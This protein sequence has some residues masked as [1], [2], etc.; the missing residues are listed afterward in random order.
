MPLASGRHPFKKGCMS[1]NCIIAFVLLAV[2]F[3]FGLQASVIIS[4]TEFATTDWNETAVW[5]PS[6]A[7]GTTAWATQE[8]SGGNPGAYRLV[9]Y[10]V[11]SPVETTIAFASS[12]QAV[13][14]SPASQGAISSINFRADLRNPT[15]RNIAFAW[16][17]EQGG[18]Y[19]QGGWQVVPAD[20]LGGNQWLPYAEPPLTAANFNEVTASGYDWN[21]HPDFDSGGAIK[22]GFWAQ[23][24]TLGDNIPFWLH[25]DNW[26]ASLTTVPE[27]GGVVVL[28]TVGAIALIAIFA[29]RRS[30][31]PIK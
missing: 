8:T 30:P 15:P 9:A 12:Y 22:F 11:I 7:N 5:N 18:K 20:F 13:T 16:L 31:S 24:S 26:Q 14:Y 21:S 28:A 23:D 4:D 6:A 2:T 29:S 19:Y 3:S 27:P 17:A 10:N 1:R 25:V